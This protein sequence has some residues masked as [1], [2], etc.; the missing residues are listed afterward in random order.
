MRKCLIFVCAAIL[1]FSLCSCGNVNNVTYT[2]GDSAYFSHEEIQSAMD[3]VKQYFLYHRPG[4]TLHN[5]TYNE[6]YAHDHYGH[7][8]DGTIVIMDGFT[9]GKNPP[10]GMDPDTPYC[11]D[12][13][14][15]KIQGTDHWQITGAGESGT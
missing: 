8:A 15:S 11:W 2:I 7:G 4:C 9:T 10:F 13:L 3:F 1:C 5:L 12:W 14:V 6:Q